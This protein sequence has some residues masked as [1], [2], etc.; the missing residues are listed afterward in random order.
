MLHPLD[1][2][3]T[4]AL[5][6]QRH[7]KLARYGRPPRRPARRHPLTALLRS[8]LARTTEALAAPHAL[9]PD[10][11]AIEPAGSSR[12]LRS[13]RTVAVALALA[14][15]TLLSGC[16]AGASDGAAGEPAQAPGDGADR[17]GTQ[18]SASGAAARTT[19]YIGTRWTV[20]DARASSEAPTGSEPDDDVTYVYVT[21]AV[22]NTLRDTALRLPR[23]LFHL[24]SP[25]GAVSRSEGLL[26][27]ELDSTIRIEPGEVLT[28]DLVFEFER[29]VEPSD[30][31][32]TIQERGK[33]PAVLPLSGDLP[34]PPHPTGVEIS[35]SRET[36]TG[37]GSFRDARDVVV[38][39]LD[40]DVGLDDG[41]RRSDVGTYFVFVELRAHG[42]DLPAGIGASMFHLEVD[43]VARSTSR[44]EGDNRIRPGEAIDRR[45]VFE[46]PLD[47]EQLVL[48]VGRP[49]DEQARFPIEFG[50]SPSG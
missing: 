43:G 15:V 12:S 46:V 27:T 21:V 32:L 13:S 4:R 24:R 8:L 25:E 35:S 23:G 48:V 36:V 49:G 17:E 39:P 30:F 40:V 29:A 22:E 2:N 50:A 26:T 3:A 37:A 44:T 10:L 34:A 5:L 11:G 19:T 1:D 9:T 38:E 16:D 7:E 31:T 41:R 47:A 33:E 18:A 14:A 28:G 20:E 42:V 45:A 6:E